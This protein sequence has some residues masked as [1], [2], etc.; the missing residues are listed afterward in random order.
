MNKSKPWNLLVGLL[1]AGALTLPFL[2]CGAPNAQTQQTQPGAPNSFAPGCGMTFFAEPACEASI[3]TICCAL[4]D[5]CARDEGCSRIAQ[6]FIASDTRAK[7]KKMRG[8]A[9][10]CDG[11]ALNCYPQMGETPGMKYWQN[12]LSCLQNLKSPPGMSCGSQC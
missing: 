10:A 3:D 12:L 7:Q 8:E 5:Q 6:C 9:G 1:S 2:A 4:Q 11:S